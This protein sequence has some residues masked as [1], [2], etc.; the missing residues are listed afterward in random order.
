MTYVTALRPC[1]TCVNMQC[2]HDTA[3]GEGF[4]FFSS[5][6]HWCSI[7]YLPFYLII[8]V[9]TCVTQQS[10]MQGD[11]G[12]TRTPEGRVRIGHGKQEAVPISKL[13]HS[14]VRMSKWLRV[15]HLIHLVMR[16]LIR[17]YFFKSITGRILDIESYELLC[18]LGKIWKEPLFIFT[19]QI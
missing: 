17:T 19:H 9:F 16:T 15:N 10:A 7:E 8:Y 11:A 14:Q 1:S 6:S 2:S 5:V 3:E 13:S 18:V 4:L 12:F